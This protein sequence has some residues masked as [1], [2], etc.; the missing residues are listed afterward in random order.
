MDCKLRKDEEGKGCERCE[1]VG[2]RIPVGRVG[3]RWNDVVR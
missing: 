2:K 1:V 3:T